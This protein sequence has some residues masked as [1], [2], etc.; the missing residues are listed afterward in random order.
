[1]RVAGQKSDMGSMEY[2]AILLVATPGGL[3]TDPVQ[4]EACAALYIC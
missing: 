1:V 2:V 4:H 3:V